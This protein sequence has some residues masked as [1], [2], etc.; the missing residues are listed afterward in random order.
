LSPKIR[1]LFI[2]LS[3]VLSFWQPCTFS[4]GTEKIFLLGLLLLI[5][6]VDTSEALISIA[7]EYA[8]FRE[9]FLRYLP[10]PT[11]LVYT[12]IKDTVVSTRQC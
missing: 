1:S 8:V 3:E 6:Q 11:F 10:H 7:K 12:W 5:F 2:F 9:E 4:A